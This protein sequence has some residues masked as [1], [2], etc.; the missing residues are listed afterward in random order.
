MRQIYIWYPIL[1]AEYTEEFVQAIT[2]YFPPSVGS[3]LTLLVLAIGCVAEC[4]TITD[5][6]Q[7]RPEAIYIQAAMEMLPCVFADS[8]SRS[9]QC[10]LLFSIYH[11]CCARPCQAHDYVVMASYRLQNYL[12]K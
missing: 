3:C 1:H 4:E 12:I 7:R 2:S 10:L 9:A 6:V 5:A 8:S 11:L